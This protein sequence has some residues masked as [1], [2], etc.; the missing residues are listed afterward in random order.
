[1]GST[2]L[3]IILLDATSALAVSRREHR[4]LRS[5]VMRVKQ[6]R[7]IIVCN[8]LAYL[9]KS[10]TVKPKGKGGVDSPP[11]KPKRVT[12]LDFI[13]EGFWNEVNKAEPDVQIIEQYL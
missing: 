9:P 8:I 1:V 3:I 12:L 7:P 10:S 6:R 2:P 5:N 4:S 13:P 11:P